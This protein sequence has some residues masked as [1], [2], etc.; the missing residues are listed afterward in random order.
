VVPQEQEEAT[1]G[2]KKNR[3]AVEVHLHQNFEETNTMTEQEY[4]EGANWIERRRKLQIAE[5]NC[6]P[7]TWEM[8]E[9]CELLFCAHAA[10]LAVRVAISCV[11]WVSQGGDFGDAG[12]GVGGAAL[13]CLAAPLGAGSCG[14]LPCASGTPSS[15]AG[16]FRRA[17]GVAPPRNAYTP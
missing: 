15:P 16:E 6:T 13:L 2:G 12:A 11:W 14:L 5:G 17:E 9:S 1:R 10:V 8:P 3:S 4:Q 7:G